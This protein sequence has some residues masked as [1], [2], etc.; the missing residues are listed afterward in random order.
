MSGHSKWATTK[1][2]KGIIDSKRG[3]IFTKL[4]RDITVA[5]RSGADPNFNFQLRLAVDRAKTSN[6]PKDN[7]ERAIARGAGEGEGGQLKEL[8]YEAVT[9]GNIALIIVAFSD[10]PN[11]TASDIKHILSKNGASL[12]PGAAMWQFEKLGVIRFQISNF[13]FQ[14]EELELIL[15]ET[16]AEDIKKEDNEIIVYTKVENLQKVKEA[17]EKEGVKI[18]DAGIEYVAKEPVEIND[19]ISEKLEKLVDAIEDNDDV[20]D[21]FTNVR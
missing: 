14:I 9:S 4:A 21:I 5:A 16:G 11:R 20:A 8:V 17:I 19:A 7:I 10:N 18:E 6:M 2:K 1:R 3:K 13:K 12:S 15:I